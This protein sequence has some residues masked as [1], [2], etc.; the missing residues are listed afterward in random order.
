MFV[1]SAVMEHIFGAGGGEKMCKEYGVGFGALLLNLS[2]R[3]QADAGRPTVVA[4]SDETSAI[5]KNI[6]RQVAI[7]VANLAKDMDRFATLWFK[8]RTILCTLRC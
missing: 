1:L 5:Y 4:D 3:E 2:I 6:A 8:H 7:R